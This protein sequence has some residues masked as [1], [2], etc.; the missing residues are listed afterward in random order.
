MFR[1][2]INSDFTKPITINGETGAWSA[3]YASAYYA[4]GKTASGVGNNVTK[5]FFIE[6]G[7]YWRLRNLSLGIDFASI[8]KLKS[9]KKLQLVFTGR[10]LLT[11]TKYSGFDPEINSAV[12]TNS[13]FD[14]GVDHSTIP[15]LK[16]YSVAL[17]VTF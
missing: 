13:A 9:I 6:D 3:Y 8:I 7:S 12:G 5:D 4:L 15:N 2:G 16:S 10:N 1:D 17:N 14:R 11:F